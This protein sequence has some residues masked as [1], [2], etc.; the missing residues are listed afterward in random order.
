MSLEERILAWSK[1]RPPWQRMA[2]QRIAAGDP[3]SAAELSELI[4]AVVAERPIRDGDLKIANLT[5]SGGR[6]LPVR[7]KSISEPTHVNALA[8]TTPLTF[9]IEGLTIVYGDNGSGKSGYARL[10]KRATRSRHNEDILTDVFRDTAAE[11]PT[12]KLS[13][14]VGDDVEELSWPSSILAELQQM[15]FYDSS[16]G[17]AYISV[18]ADFPYRPYA[19]FAMDGLIEACNTMGDLLEAKLLQ[20]S[21]AARRI[22]TVTTE[23]RET[24]GGRF[25][26][27]LSAGSSIGELDKLIARL[28][29]QE[30]SVDVVEA[31]EDALR[32]QDRGQARRNAERTAE[33]LDAIGDHVAQA[34]SVLGEAAAGE[35]SQARGKFLQ[36]QGSAEEHAEVLR[37]ESVSGIGNPAWKALWDS[38]RRFSESHAYPE[39]PFPATDVDSRCVLCLQELGGQGADVLTRLD[40]FVKDDI[41]MRLEEADRTYKGLLESRNSLQVSGGLVDDLLRDVEPTHPEE[42]RL[43]R[44]LLTRYEATQAAD[45]AEDSSLD[46]A[47]RATPTGA[48]VI[49][50]VRTAAQESRRLAADFGDPSMIQRRL[51]AVVAKR[52]EIRLLQEIQ[53]EREAI[54]Q[55]LNRLSVRKRL[56]DLKREANTGPITRKILELSEETITEVIRDRFT[57]ETDRLGLERVTI[58]K[59]RASKGALL[60]QPKLVGTRQATALSKI[61]SEG[62]RTALGLAAYFTEASLDQ[63]KSA[64]ILDDPVTSLDHIRRDQVA[65]RLVDF[66]E[67]RQ[68]VVFT[69]DVAFVADLKDAASRK[70]LDVAERGVS[71]SRGGDRLPGACV[72]SHPWKARDVQAR[73]GELRADLARMRKQSDEFDDRKYEEAV[74]SWAGKLSETWERIFSQE[75]VGPVLADGGLEVRPMMVKV[76]ARFSDDDHGEFEASYSKVSRW[77]R[78]HDKSTRLNYV[79]PELLE[80]ESELALV[81][82]WFRRVRKY[83]V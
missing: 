6:M 69:H 19:L 35:M 65:N 29:S 40:R 51:K 44:E 3:L 49:R 1:Q 53:A 56:E 27:N 7:L 71:R 25:L 46:T 77:A 68:V 62:E 24:D 8:T 58:A 17:S 38:A 5:P 72:E 76:L 82:Q 14:H 11:R 64:L 22:P 26:S 78:R 50:R 48:G 31:E 20:N 74:A 32:A 13:V 54:T 18:E 70:G 57:R 4:D 63:S 45:P 61:S 36:V 37:S 2:L 75:I 79:A 15:L 12:A 80:L 42:I 23:T 73:L 43:V 33:K 21:R 66:A 83:R 9:P 47:G 60:H 59:T 30:M 55:E 28:G 10:L 52:H 39:R 67:D 34:D 81:D 41:Q 16:C